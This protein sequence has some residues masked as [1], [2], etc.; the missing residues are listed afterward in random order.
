MSDHARNTRP[1][2]PR[3]STGAAPAPA[4]PPA[5][6]PPSPGLLD[7]RSDPDFRTTFGRLARRATEIDVAL[8]RVRLSGVDLREGELHT[9][10]SL[11]ILLGEVSALTLGTEAEA[12]LADPERARNVDLLVQLFR[13]ERIAVRSAPLGGWSP[14]FTVFGQD[15]GPSAVLV[16]PHWFQRP[17]PH[18]GPAWASL[19]G[20][21]EARWAAARFAG[22]WGAGH[23]IGA[24]VRNILERAVERAGQGTVEAGDPRRAV[25]RK[26]PRE[27][28]FRGPAEP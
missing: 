20:P 24:A 11:R 1:K 9:V 27:K 23:E 5:F 6:W 12:V 8:G 18:R 7:E 17:Y 3:R 15:T 19:H 2:T 10:R 21:R 13:E 22:L 26:R 4:A 28:G 14:D 16:G 25:A